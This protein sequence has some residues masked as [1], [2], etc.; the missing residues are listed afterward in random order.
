M[1][2]YSGVKAFASVSVAVAMLVSAFFIPE[3]FENAMK[4]SVIDKTWLSALLSVLCM[5][6]TV[7]LLGYVNASRLQYTSSSVLLYGMFG[8]LAFSFP[9]SV[10]LTRYHLAIP[11]LLT[12]LYFMLK[13]AGDEGTNVSSAFY[14]GLSVSLASVFV[15]QLVWVVACFFSSGLFRRGKDTLRFIV[16]FLTAVL[17]PWIYILSFGYLFPSS[18]LSGF[19]GQ[20][21][22][23]LP[24]GRPEFPE[25]SPWVIAYAVLC[26]SIALRSILFVSTGHI[27]KNREQKYAFS[28]SAS[29]SIL[30]V[31]IYCLYSQSLSPMFGIVAAL[32]SS[33]CV[34]AFVTKGNRFE[35]AVYVSLLLVCAIMLRLFQMDII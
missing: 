23:M 28:F 14:S 32:P 26:L 1:M 12:A 31:A 16:S 35:S 34:F 8:V 19:A 7:T 18:C 2:N 21:F 15:P 13:Y 20:F 27:E 17:V 29:L 5:S 4:V 10:V 3:V 30:M 33:F 6:F 22:G 24:F 25:A 11:M 9:E